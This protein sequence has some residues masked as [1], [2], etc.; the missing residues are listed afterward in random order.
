LEAADHLAAGRQA[1]AAEQ[2]EPAYVALTTAGKTLELE[3]EDLQRLGETA[4]WT[5]RADEAVSFREKAYGVYIKEGKREA[6]ALIALTLAESYK[7]RLAK[8]VSKAWVARAESLID[9]DTPTEAYGYLLRWK[10][11]EAFESA[12]QPEKAFELAEQVMEVGIK[13]GDRSL[14]ALGLQ[15]KGRFL[16]ATGRIDEGMALV[17]EAMVAAVAGELS[18]DATGRSYC[19]MLS[20]CDQVADYQRAG[21]WSAAAE[22]WCEQHSDS[23]Y[24]GVCRIFRAELKWLRGD[25]PSAVTDLDRAMS[26]LNGFTPIVG[27]A[28]YQKAEVALRAGSLEDAEVLF[29]AAH[30]HGYSALPGLAELRLRQGDPEAAGQLIRDALSGA[31]LGPLARAKF[32]PA[33]IDT[34]MALGHIE[35]SR[36]ALAEL[37]EVA[38]LCASIAM[39]SAAGQRRAVIS[40]AEDRPTDAIQELRSAILGWTELQMPY[41]MAQAR[42]LLAEAQHVVGVDSAARLELSAARSAFKT[43]G[44][45]VDLGRIEAMVG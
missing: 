10:S 9:D 6:A 32:L 43:L 23:A 4:H 22:A 18:T 28:L 29:G 1:H 5:G 34:E 8:A 38:T 20:I 12:G 19:N 16:V 3:A 24:P 27:A 21:E 2:W 45:D 30:E 36:Q 14:H 31:N 33:Q 42:L 26:E 17:D 11:V 44:A 7:Y 40:L 13:L 37:E 41:E 35:E 39:R 15:D 25:W